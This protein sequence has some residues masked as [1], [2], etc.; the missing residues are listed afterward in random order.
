MDRNS[1]MGVRLTVRGMSVGTEHLRWQGIHDLREI[2]RHVSAALPQ[3][4][5]SSP[6]NYCTAGGCVPPSWLIWSL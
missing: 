6:N 3:L 5:R 1:E 4:C 2:G